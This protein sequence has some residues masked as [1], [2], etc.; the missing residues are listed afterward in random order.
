M[1]TAAK[2][3]FFG[4]LAVLA[5]VQAQA[6]SFPGRL[7]PGRVWGNPSAS[8]AQ[9][10]DATVTSIIDRAF[11]STP[12][13][14]LSRGTSAWVAAT[15]TA[16]LVINTTTGVL[17]L[18]IGTGLSSGGSNL[19]L[20]N[21][22]V[23]P[24][25][26]GDA[27]HVPQITVNAQGQITGMTSVLITGGGG[28]SPGGSNL[29]GQYNLAGAFAGYKL[30][31]F[32]ASIYGSIPAAVTA[33]V[34]AGGGIVE[35]PC[36]VYSLGSSSVG[37]NLDSTHNIHLTG[38]GTPNGGGLQCVTLSYT[39]TG[40]AISAKQSL[41]LEIDH[42]S[43][44]G[45]SS[46]TVL[47][48]S[49]I[50]SQ[51][52]T[53]ANIHD[54]LLYGS[55]S[56]IVIDLDDADIIKIEYNSIGGGTTATGIRGVS[57]TG[58]FSNKVSIQHNFFQAL[59]GTDIAAPGS[60]W[61]ISYNTIEGPTTTAL[62]P[63]PA[64]ICDTLTLASNWMGDETAGV[65]WGTFSCSSI[66]S[67]GNV[68]GHATT[69]IDLAMQNS[70][71]SLTSIGDH[72]YGTTAVAAGTGNKVAIITPDS[73]GISTITGT[74]STAALPVLMQVPA[75]TMLGN[76]TGS[77][78]NAAANAM[79]SCSDTGGNHLNY[80]SGTGVTCGTSDLHTGTITALTGDVTA[81]GS[82]SVPA[83]LANIPSAVPMAGSLLAT[84]IAA[85]GTPAA[86][87]ASIYVDSTT[88]AVT[89]KD[90]AGVLHTTV[91][92]DTGAA[93]NFLTAIS[94]AG[95]ISKAQPAFTNL[96]GSASCAQLPALTG[97]A[98]SSACATTLATVNSNVGS[99]GSSTAIPVVTV[100]G[101][102]LVTAASTAV[103]IAPAG[104][105]TGA[106]LAANVLASSLTSVGTLSGGAVPTTL[107]TGAL[108]A[109]QE[110]AHTGDMTNTA[111]SLATVVGAI[112][113]KA[114]SLGGAFTTSGAFGTTLTVTATTNSTLPAGTHTLAALDLASQTISG[115]ANVTTL[116][117]STGNITVDCGARPLQSITNNGAYTITAPAADGSCQILVTNGASAG[118]TTFTGFTIGASPVVPGTVNG[119]KFL[120]MIARVGGTST[121]LVDALQ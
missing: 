111:G 43:I 49:G 90:D 92:A 53:L 17:S 107:L 37:L 91:V 48:L 5:A 1:R 64:G 100:N 78:A 73:A 65:T 41:G 70:T 105:L 94:A 120:I 110:P 63:T 15:A 42:L 98:T 66:I 22:A 10:S 12:G 67:T 99:F 87:K 76:W 20:S 77:Q 109:A 71:G 97:D 82:G 54:N 75:N 112:G 11:G 118:A 35:V 61:D 34:A 4:G 30:P 7:H 25:T 27:T 52:T 83:T 14:F 95:V 3:L 31:S 32:S 13:T 21:T 55:A 29:D 115:G 117:L 85:P 96:S 44:V 33:A 57:A 18:G 84:A 79:P 50:I 104:T 46:A 68:Y 89:N 74:P 2:A 23:T 59:L 69:G 6:Q 40:T 47:D 86:G 80:V 56:G 26:G 106:T 60:A 119:N 28:G 116:A 58:H 81:S 24:G 108:Q 93:N 88:K 45:T 9:A 62:S 114:V 103:V 113:G 72:F 51:D 39:G 19:N 101:K 121:Y 36:G 16:P 102:G 8:E 38:A